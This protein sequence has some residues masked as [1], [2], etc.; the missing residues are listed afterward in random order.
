M[1]LRQ[2]VAAVLLL[3][4]GAAA[5][6]ELSGTVGVV[7]DYDFRGASQTSKDPALQGSIDWASESGFYVGAWG[8]NIDYGPGVDGDHA[9][10]GQVGGHVLQKGHLFAGGLQQG[11]AQPGADQLWTRN[12]S[13]KAGFVR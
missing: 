4:S 7:S 6:A 8:S 11:E 2:G 9:L 10:Q 5:H 13:L 1:K 12:R 3:V